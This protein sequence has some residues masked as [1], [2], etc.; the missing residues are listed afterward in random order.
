M[1]RRTASRLILGFMVPFLLAVPS[2]HAVF[3]DFNYNSL[4]DG[5]NNA[6]VDG[7]MQGII[8]G[9]HPGGTIAVTGSRAEANYTGDNHVVGPTVP[10]VYSE[11]LGTSDANIHHALPLDTFLVNH[12]STK[13]EMV[14]SFPVYYVSFDYEIFPDGTCP[15]S[16]CSAANWPDFTFEANDVVQF[17][18]LGV[19]PGTSG[20]YPHSPFSGPV[21]NEL[22]PQFLGMSGDYFFAN[23]VTKLEFID[24]PRMIGI[25]NLRL[26]DD[27]CIANDCPPPPPPPPVIP[28]PTSLLLMGSGLLGIGGRRLFRKR[29]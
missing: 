13:I 19:V 26:N 24:W 11:T 3:M 8:T 7:Y 6:A 2:A 5:N 25:D 21:T 15:T 17:N 29:A 20:T 1:N 22:A 18:K 28:E 12:E 14:F 16:S 10:S 4:A 23:G 9:A 27:R